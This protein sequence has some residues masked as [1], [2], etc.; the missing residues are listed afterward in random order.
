VKILLGNEYLEVIDAGTNSVVFTS[1]DVDEDDDEDDEA[2]EEGNI[3]LGAVPLMY[4]IKLYKNAQAQTADK[5]VR[6]KAYNMTI[7]AL[8]DLSAVLLLINEHGQAVYSVAWELVH[9]IDSEPCPPI[10]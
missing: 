10:E 8:T 6:V 3:P 7:S 1:N 4:K 2:E 9:S 5:T